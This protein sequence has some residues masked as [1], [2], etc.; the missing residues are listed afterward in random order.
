MPIL[1]A[2]AHDDAE[3]ADAVGADGLPCAGAVPAFQPEPWWRSLSAVALT[4]A[5]FFVSAAFRSIAKRCVHQSGF[6]PRRSPCEK[7][8]VNSW[9]IA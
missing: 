3:E 8:A 2:D 5:A 7:A 6:E 1:Q 4:A 9:S